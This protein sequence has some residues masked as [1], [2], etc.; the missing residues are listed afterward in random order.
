[1][2]PEPFK[3]GNLR[4]LPQYLTISRGQQLR[5]IDLEH[6]ERLWLFVKNN[7]S[8]FRYLPVQQAWQYIGFDWVIP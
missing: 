2:I 8:K 7:K 6:Y 3:N 4:K 5:D 1:M